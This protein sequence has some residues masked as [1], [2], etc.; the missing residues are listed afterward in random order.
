MIIEE[1]IIGEIPSSMSVPLFEAR[2]TRNQYM[3]S[4]MDRECFNATTKFFGFIMAVG[5]ALAYSL[6]GMYGPPDQLG[7]FNLTA[8]IL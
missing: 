3:G 6:S 7:I 1:V 5:E 8:I 4:Q 2:M